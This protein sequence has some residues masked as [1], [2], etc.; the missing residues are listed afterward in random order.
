MQTLSLANKSL[1]ERESWYSSVSLT[2]SRAFKA[3]LLCTLFVSMYFPSKVGGS[4]ETCLTQLMFVLR[5]T[6]IHLTLWRPVRSPFP[7][8]LIVS[9]LAN[10]LRSFPWF[11]SLSWC[12]LPAQNKPFRHPTR[13]TEVMRLAKKIQPPFGIRV[14]V[15]PL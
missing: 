5:H 6:S 13:E 12:Y 15:R 1:I 7:S 14:V 3:R 2:R 8:R 10:S 11:V 4:S 9:L